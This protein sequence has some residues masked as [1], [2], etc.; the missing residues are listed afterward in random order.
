MFFKRAIF[1]INWIYIESIITLNLLHVILGPLTVTT[2]NVSGFKRVASGGT[3]TVQNYS[4]VTGDRMAPARI[5]TLKLINSDGN[6]FNLSWN[7]VGDDLNVG[8]CE[9][10][11]LSN[12]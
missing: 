11:I 12:N 4:T 10:H 2:E 3:Y 5:T 9:F 6:V 1:K 7:A 8:T